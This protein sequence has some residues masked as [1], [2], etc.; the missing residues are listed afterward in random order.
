M[1]GETDGDQFGFSVSI[2]GDY[3][4]VGAPYYGSAVLGAAYIFKKDNYWPFF[5]IAAEVKL[6]GE[7]DGDYFGISVSINGDYAIVGAYEYD[8][9]DKRGAAYIYNRE[10]IDEKTG[11]PWKQVSG[12][13]LLEG[14][15]TG[16]EFGTSVAIDGPN[17][18]VG[19]PGVEVNKGAAHIY[20]VERPGLAGYYRAVMAPYEREDGKPP[21]QKILDV[22]FIPWSDNENKVGSKRELGDL[23]YNPNSGTLMVVSKQAKHGTNPNQIAICDP[24]SGEIL[25][26]AKLS[27]TGK[28][29]E[30]TWDAS[31][32]IVL[33]Q[34]DPAGPIGSKIRS[35]NTGTGN[36]TEVD[37]VSE[38]IWDLSEWISQPCEE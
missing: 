27:I 33:S 25:H 36:E 22:N 2:N 19:A 13:P 8:G 35:L 34:Y 17:A 32:A 38:N 1:E 20:N 3:A 21:E 11:K 7:N 15:I 29:N 26:T 4:I 30:I 28:N 16:D 37:E 31:G 5:T 10:C 23:A 14:K 9:Q 18:L 12:P 6:E 24:S